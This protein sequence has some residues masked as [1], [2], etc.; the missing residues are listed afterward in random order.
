MILPP[1]LQYYDNYTGS[2][3]GSD[4]GKPEYQRVYYHKLNTEQTED[5]KIF[6]FDDKPLWL[7]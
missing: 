4:T 5:I 6:G 7:M 3:E 2:G 1:I